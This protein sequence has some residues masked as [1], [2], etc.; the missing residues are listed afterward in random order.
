M[1][2]HLIFFAAKQQSKVFLSLNRLFFYLFFFLRNEFVKLATKRELLI[3]KV[4]GLVA[5]ATV[6]VAISISEYVLIYV[7]ANTVLSSR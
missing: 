5:L 3:D 7:Y 2:F 6:L 1:N 4:E